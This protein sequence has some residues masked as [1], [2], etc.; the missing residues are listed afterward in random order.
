M[1]FGESIAGCRRSAYIQHADLLRSPALPRLAQF[2][3]FF[4]NFRPRFLTTILTS[5]YSG[6]GGKNCLATQRLRGMSAG[7]TR[8]KTRTGITV[9]PAVKRPHASYNAIH[10]R[11]L[12]LQTLLW[13]C[14]VTDFG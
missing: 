8:G 9:Y 14:A 2:T 7:G 6:L 13:Q 3:H 10:Q 11:K 5:T 12:F 4:P 1:R